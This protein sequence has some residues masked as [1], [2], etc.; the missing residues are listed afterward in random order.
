MWGGSRTDGADVD[1]WVERE[2]CGWWRHCAPW[3]ERVKGNRDGG[4]GGDWIAL[5]IE[6]GGDGGGGKG[7][8]RV[9]QEWD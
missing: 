3:F 1:V 7:D 2:E 4:G 9:G 6:E 8:E 5:R